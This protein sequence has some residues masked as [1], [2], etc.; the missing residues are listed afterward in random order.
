MSAGRGSTVTS[1]LILS[2]DAGT[3]GVTAL[4]VDASARVVASGYREF[5]QH[6]PADDRVDA[7][8]VVAHAEVGL[9]DAR[10]GCG[11]GVRTGR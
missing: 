4:V 2:I 6:F 7:V 5:E 9:C 3:T 11:A 10:R 1:D 8:G